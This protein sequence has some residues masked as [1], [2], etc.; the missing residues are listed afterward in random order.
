MSIDLI[1]FSATHMHAT[2]CGVAIAGDAEGNTCHAG[3]IAGPDNL[4]MVGDNLV[5][6]EDCE[7]RHINAYLW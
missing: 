4:E 7:G 1:T 2:V 5:I 6:A 3:A